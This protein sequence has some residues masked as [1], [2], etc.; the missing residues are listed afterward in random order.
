M[1][2][3]IMT[4]DAQEPRRKTRSTGGQ[5]P[6]PQQEAGFIISG[7]Q[8]TT[9]NR[10]PAVDAFTSE[11]TIRP[12]KINADGGGKTIL[13]RTESGAQPYATV[14]PGLVERVLAGLIATVKSQMP[15]KKAALDQAGRPLVR[16]R[17][18]DFAL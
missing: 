6:I 5:D 15:V 17:D 16:T 2:K 10:R 9:V 18:D 11:A 14:K 4:G 3:L 12:S 1:P 13:H 8:I 7:P